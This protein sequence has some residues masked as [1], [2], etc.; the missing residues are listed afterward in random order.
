MFQHTVIQYRKISYIGQTKRVIFAVFLK[1]CLLFNT[2]PNLCHFQKPESITQRRLPNTG[3]FTISAGSITLKGVFIFLT[4]ISDLN[5]IDTCNI[6]IINTFWESVM[7]SFWKVKYWDSGY[8]FCLR[9]I[10]LLLFEV[11]RLL[12]HP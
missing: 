7:I 8:Q 2:L 1:Q 11:L 5:N 12:N 3:H 4:Q 6:Y 9:R 10:I